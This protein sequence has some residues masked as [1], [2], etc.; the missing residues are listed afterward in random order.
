MVLLLLGKCSAVDV[1]RT[2]HMEMGGLT[3]LLFAWGC[4][5]LVD[6]SLEFSMFLVGSGLIG[7]FLSGLLLLGDGDDH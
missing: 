7:V 5:G 6:I 2:M 3:G 4:G 1:P